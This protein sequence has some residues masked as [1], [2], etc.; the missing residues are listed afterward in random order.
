MDKVQG[1]GKY[2]AEQIQV[3]EGLEAI[4]RRPGM[5]IGSTDSRGLHHLFF[6]VLDNSIDES[7]AGFCDHIV[8]TINGDGSLTVTDNGRGI[9]VDLHPKLN[10]PAVEVVLTTLHAGGKFGSENGGYKVSGGLHGVGI[11]VVNALSSFLRVEVRRDGKVYRQEFSRGKPLMELSVVG[12]DSAT[13]T[14]IT[15]RPDPEIF[16]TTVFDPEV[17]IYRLRELAF[18]NKGVTL[19]FRDENTGRG[20]IWQYQG[21][22]VSF[23]EHLVKN[24]DPV[25]REVIYYQKDVGQVNVEVALQYT[26]GYVETVF[27]FCNNIHTREGGTHLSGF[28]SALTR[29]LNDYARRSGLLK[30]N[31]D[32]LS[33]EDVREGCIAIVNVQIPD[34][35]FEGQTKT[36]LGNSEVRGVVESVVA[37]GLGLYL[38]ENPQEARKIIEKALAAARAREAARK[39]RELTRRKNALEV[40]SLP[41]KLADCT[42]S[43]PAEA[44]LYL[45]EGDSAGGTAKQGRDRRFQAIL[46][47]RGKILN[48]EKARMDKILANNEIRAMITALG[49]GIGEDFDEE[50]LRYHRIIIMSV[51]Y[52]ELAFVRRAADGMVQSVLVGEFIDECIEGKRFFQDYEVL[53]FDLETKKTCFRPIRTVIRHPLQD[54]LLRIK[55]ELGREVKVTGGHSVFLWQGEELVLKPADEIKPGDLVA[56]PKVIP[57]FGGKGGSEHLLYILGA[58]MAH[59]RRSPVLGPYLPAWGVDLDLLRHHWGELTGQRLALR[60]RR[61]KPL[62]LLEGIGELLDGLIPGDGRIPDLVF[63]SCPKAQ[64]AFLAGWRRGD[65]WPCRQKIQAGGLVYLLGS[66]GILAKIEE[67]GGSYLVQ[68]ADGEGV[69][70]DLMAL[71]VASVEEA[72]PTSRYVYDFSVEEDENFI[73]GLGGI[74]C[75]NTDADVDGAHIRTLLLTFFFRYMRPLI[76]NGHIYVAQPPLYRVR[77]GS[78]SRYAYS[79]EE[80]DRILEEI[81]RKGVTIQRYKG[82]GEMNAEQLWETTMNPETRTLIRLELTDAMAADA[83]FTTLMGEKVEPRREFI[84]EH[85]REVGELDI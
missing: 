62:V 10:R 21:G 16:E 9:P 33:G 13:G 57:Q 20:G 46:P 36:K 83:I 47:L 5:Y 84:Q 78:E 22:I 68:E 11:A 73:A 3:L 82:L 43:D 64:D 76:D 50:K 69:L 1:P 7:L 72:L 52:E 70:G 19:E 59:G 28:R 65:G 24:K 23:V 61:R 34:P 54:R 14:T 42:V 29:T 75:H 35:Q 26:T 81:G 8:V 37:E 2:D 6:E 45:V 25:N 32:N 27:T 40:S 31:E 15:F 49:T 66:R 63:N 85:A 39:A 44:E 77:K 74:C 58:Y 60:W 18:L 55:T 4:R 51:D 56:A 17:V 80:L 53:C 38:E 71:K 79:E 12:E 67:R 30:E 41:G 48:V